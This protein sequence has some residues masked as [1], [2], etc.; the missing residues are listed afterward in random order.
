[1][2][3]IAIDMDDTLLNSQNIVTQAQNDFLIHLIREKGIK[4]VIST[5]RLVDGIK[6][7]LS[8]ELYELVYVIALNGSLIL[9]N[10][11]TIVK[12]D[13]I[14][15]KLF[16]ELLTQ[17]EDYKLDMSILDEFNYYRFSPQNNEFMDHEEKLNKTTIRYLDIEESKNTNILKSLIFYH[18]SERKKIE[19]KV[20]ESTIPGLRTIFTQP[21]LVEFLPIETNKGTALEYLAN[22]LDIDMKDT[23]AIGDGTNDIE[24]MGRA[25]HAI[26]MGN[27]IEEVKNISDFVT[28]SNNKDGVKVGIERLLKGD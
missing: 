25:G 10:D 5:G 12:S 28:L 15:N 11:K 3:L 4:I 7:L 6:N 24:L 8:P 21:Y 9:N 14:T 19:N 23:I 17:F 2:K 20:L 22:Y 13:Q 26:A 18:P 1:M 27:A 16:K